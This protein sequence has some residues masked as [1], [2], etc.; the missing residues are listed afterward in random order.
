MVCPKCG[1]ILADDAQQCQY[2]G[3][4][5]PAKADIKEQKPENVLAG[6]FGALL[7]AILGGGVV[8]LLGRLGY[9]ATLSGIAVVYCTMVFYDL[10]A[11]RKAKKGLAICLLLIA[12]TP[13]IA[14][15]IDWALLLMKESGVMTFGEAF[16][17]VPDMIGDAIVAKDYFV[18]LLMLY[19]FAVVGAGGALKDY[20][21]DN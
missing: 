21:H 16:V 2:C 3:K 13:Y 8:L 15:R 10:F 5:I 14:D 20:F 18:H 1:A 4:Q 7:G 12:V 6:T 9:V 11:G 19:G 17:R